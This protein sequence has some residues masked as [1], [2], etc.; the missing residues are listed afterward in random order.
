MSDRRTEVDQTT[1]KVGQPGP[2]LGVDRLEIGR[3]GQLKRNAGEMA[4]ELVEHQASPP[5]R[6]IENRGNFAINLFKDHEM[7]EVPVQD[8]G[9][10]QAGKF[11]H[12]QPHGTCG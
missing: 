3:G 8:R 7:V 9:K 5:S 1:P 4:R 10:L 11:L 2:G 6:R 12:F